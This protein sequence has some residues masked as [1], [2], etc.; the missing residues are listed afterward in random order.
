MNERRFNQ[1]ISRAPPRYHCGQRTP[2]FPA[3]ETVLATL[4]RV[5][6]GDVSRLPASTWPQRGPHGELCDRNLAL[7]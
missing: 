1:K 7:H 4:E 6:D 3:A 2:G 5:A